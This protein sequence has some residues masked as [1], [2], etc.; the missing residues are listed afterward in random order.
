MKT[1]LLFFIFLNLNVFAYI[2]I[3]PVTFD[4]KIDGRGEF[5]EYTLYNPTQNSLKYQLYL[6]DEKIEKSM[7]TWTEIYPTTITLKPGQS[8]KFKVFIKAP[9]N[10]QNDEYFVTVGIK[11]MSLP[12]LDSKK[13]S[14]IQILTHLKMDL[15]GYVGD[16]NLNLKIQN[17]A[18]SLEKKYLKFSGILSNKGARRGNLDFYLVKKNEDSEFYIG[19]LRVLKNEKINLSKLNQ[20][21]TDYDEDLIN[22]FEEYKLLIIRDSSNY[23]EIERVKI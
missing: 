2:N 3:N 15:V 21:L 11:E 6:E 7:K 23:E 20:N 14:T 4:K 18:I 17:F 9:P 22:N 13:V 16:L 1:I 5:Q 19:N 12:K 8:G 10:T